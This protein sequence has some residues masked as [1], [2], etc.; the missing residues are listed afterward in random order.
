M[1]DGF[2]FAQVGPPWWDDRPVFLVGT[3]PSLVGFDFAR[4]R[5]LGY[6]LSVK[7]SWPDVGSF[8]D[9]WFCL[10]LH[11]MRRVPLAVQRIARKATA[12]LAIDRALADERPLPAPVIAGAVYLK[13]Y[14]LNVGLS[15]DPSQI[16]CG[17]NSGFG[18]FNVAYL[19]R[20][21]LIVLLG[22]DYTGAPY[23]PHRYSHN[24]EGH[25]ER[26][27]ERWAGNFDCTVPQLQRDGVRVINAS[28]LSAVRAFPRMSIEQAMGEVS[29][30][31]AKS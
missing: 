19:K 17:A 3:G 15:E 14:R 20:A 12:Y 6:V 10:D 22:F 23:C 21:K 9:A 4:L 11:T 7:N 29:A 16:E 2:P 30:W 8:A 1:T 5:G 26:Y 28:Q 25:N 13:S 27:L 24:P 31:N 18:A